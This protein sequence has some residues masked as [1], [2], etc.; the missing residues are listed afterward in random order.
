MNSTDKIRA[1]NSPDEQTK[2]RMTRKSIDKRRTRN[3]TDKRRAQ[4]SPDKQNKR[5]MTRNFSDKN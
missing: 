5:K 4:N 1:K 3:S 2:K